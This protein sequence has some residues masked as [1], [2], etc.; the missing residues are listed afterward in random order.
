MAVRLIPIKSL[1]KTFTQQ[2]VVVYDP[3]KTTKYAK[4]LN[5]KW[6]LYRPRTAWALREVDYLKIKAILDTG[7][8]IFVDGIFY[9]EEKKTRSLERVKE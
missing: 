4:T 3:E 6:Y 1:K 7:E 9:L 8:N 5:S 2:P